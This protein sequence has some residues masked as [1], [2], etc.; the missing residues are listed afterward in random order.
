MDSCTA[1]F[2]RDQ[3]LPHEHHVQRATR[4]SLQRCYPFHVG[5]LSVLVGQHPVH[6]DDL[7][8]ID[9]LQELDHVDSL[10]EADALQSWLL[11]ALM[12]QLNLCHLF[13]HFDHQDHDLVHHS[14][15]DRFV[16]HVQELGF[17]LEAMTIPPHG[18]G[19]C[20]SDPRLESLGHE[21]LPPNQEKSS[22]SHCNKDFLLNLLPCWLGF[23]DS[24]D[25]PLHPNA[26]FG[27]YA[28]VLPV[29]V[30]R[31]L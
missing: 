21:L 20:A 7:F 8:Q 13:D 10:Q 29:V 27:P 30:F 11:M 19:R 31:L 9:A 17:Q 6:V 16:A 26:L 18:F 28:V 12:V 15:M 22:V 23:V 3:V 14:P 24:A 25:A 5:C 4:L 2:G 1:H